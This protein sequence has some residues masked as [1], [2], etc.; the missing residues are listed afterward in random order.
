MEH[1]LDADLTVAKVEHLRRLAA[2]TTDIGLQPLSHYFSWRAATVAADTGTEYLPASDV[3]HTCRFCGKLL[4]PRTSDYVRV[5]ARTSKS[6]ANQGSSGTD[7]NRRRRQTPQRV[8]VEVAQS[9]SA[10]GR[11]TALVKIFRKAKKSA[12]KKKKATPASVGT[13]PAPNEQGCTN[14][15]QQQRQQQQ[16][17]KDGKGPSKRKTPPAPNFI[18]LGDGFGAGSSAAGRRQRSSAST[19]RKGHNGGV[20]PKRARFQHNV[21]SKAQVSISPAQALLKLPE[22]QRKKK[23]KKAPPSTP[24]PPSAAASALKGFLD[25]VSGL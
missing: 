24:K 3:T 15:K 11:S 2:F 9:C 16:Q 22:K 18:S 6:P 7:G 12:K 4:S 8:K 19:H 20:E 14:Q 1:V 5:T 25:A 10:C 17:E 21:P 13:R 23:K